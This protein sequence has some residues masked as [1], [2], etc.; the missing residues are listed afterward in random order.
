MLAT[1]LPLMLT[2]SLTQTPAPPGHMDCEE[3][4]RIER[5][6]TALAPHEI[7]VSPGRMTGVVF[8]VPV[9]VELQEE[10]RFE[11]VSRGRTSINVMPP[12]DMAPGERLRLS[13][14]YVD[15]NHQEDALTL[16]LV[17]SPDQSTRQVEVFRDTRTR[18][19]FERELE[20]ERVERQRSQQELTRLRLELEQLRQKYADPRQLHW[21][22]YSHSM[23]RE[24]VRART[25]KKSLIGQES[26]E[27]RVDRGVSYRSK[28]RVAIELWL[29]YSGSVPW[30]DIGIE[31]Q[32]SSHGD[33]PIVYSWQQAM[34]EVNV[35]FMM[36]I[37][38][39][40]AS[41]WTSVECNLILR[42]D[43]GRRLIIRGIEFP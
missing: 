39:E 20:Q 40:A 10:F 3:T 18:E 23:T 37:E 5:T 32:R 42:D 36:I 27:L 22:I 33:W 11:E 2:L 9:S 15:G 41:A 29:V 6:R 16:F 7:C 1:S 21:L 28:Y 31:V 34:P 25:F 43:L 19:S 13:A 4:Q 17:A 35:A 8:D 12:K 26:N 30:N 24:G 14:R 38:M